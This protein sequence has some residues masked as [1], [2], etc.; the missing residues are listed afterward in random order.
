LPGEN[1]QLNFSHI[2]PTAMFRR[3][4]KAKALNDPMRFPGWKSRI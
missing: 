2:Q 3:K 1:A 4:M